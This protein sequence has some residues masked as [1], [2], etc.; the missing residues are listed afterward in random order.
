MR[1][2][3]FIYHTKKAETAPKF[4]TLL[5]DMIAGHVLPE[6]LDDYF[7]VSYGRI[8]N[9]ADLNG[10][11]VSDKMLALNI[12]KNRGFNVPKIWN[13]SDY[14]HRYKW[15]RYIPK[16]MFPLL[17]RKIHHARGTDIIFLRNGGSIFKRLKKVLKRQVFVEYIT[18]IKEFRVHVLGE[19]VAFIQEKVRSELTEIHHPHVWSRER[20]WTL[21]NYEG[22]FCEKLE[23]L[24]IGAI[25]ALNYDFG[26]VDIG[27]STSGKFYVFEVNS[28]PRLT[29]E[30]RRL[31]AKYFRTKE[32][33]NREE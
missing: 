11:I 23:E 17:A 13:I 9:K 8:T 30:R 21:E 2:K 6:N 33:E 31:Y 25:K 20:G 29:I 5:K 12:L 19:E 1:K 28:A 32:K 14:S 16:E 18:K 26:A 27:L 7:I 10:N 22:E 3:I 24:G 15:W 4:L